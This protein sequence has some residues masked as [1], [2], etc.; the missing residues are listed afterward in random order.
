MGRDVSVLVDREETLKV[1]SRFKESPDGQGS[2]VGTFETG[3]SLYRIM[4]GEELRR[5]VRSGKILG[6]MFAVKSERAYGASWG[7][8]I[9]QVIAWGNRA[10]GE[11]LGSELFLAKIDASG[12]KFFHL[13]PKIEYDSASPTQTFKM[14]VSQCSVGLGCSIVGVA[15]DEAQFYSV[16]TAGH[17]TPLSDADLK[18]AL[19]GLGSEKVVELRQ[20]SSVYYHGTMYGTDVYVAMDQ[21]NSAHRHTWGVYTR[22]DDPIVIG[23]K[24]DKIAID[25]A[26]KILRHGLLGVPT[27]D[28]LPK[29]KLNEWRRRQPPNYAR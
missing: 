3:V 22:D 6:G 16:D 29:S 8:D 1:R 21:T 20:I 11:R 15:F 5:V 10:R 27:L 19:K 17:I 23:A 25:R 14:D 2:I 26:A 9:S 24:S 12:K 7:E 28:L 13:N 4:D 18:K